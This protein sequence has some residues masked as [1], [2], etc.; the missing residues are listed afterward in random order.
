MYIPFFYA[1]KLTFK[2][3][4]GQVDKNTKIFRH[5]IH[6]YLADLKGILIPLDFLFGEID[7]SLDEASFP[8]DWHTTRNLTGG[9]KNRRNETGTRRRGGIK[10]ES[11]TVSGYRLIGTNYLF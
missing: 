5:L 8:S 1:T 7:S 9:E 11:Y 3:L 2:E 10:K 6:T 4:P